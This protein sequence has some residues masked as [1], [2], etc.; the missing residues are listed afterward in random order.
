[1]TDV[2][3]G[4][5]VRFSVMDADMRPGGVVH[6]GA[7]KFGQAD[8]S[9]TAQDGCNREVVR[10]DQRVLPGGHKLFDGRPGALLQFGQ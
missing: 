8:V 4:L 9:Q 2:I 1:M 10:D 5:D 7:A 6:A 3:D